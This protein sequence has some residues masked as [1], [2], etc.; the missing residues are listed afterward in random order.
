MR[1]A[2][3]ATTVL[4]LVMLALA[5]SGISSLAPRLQAATTPQLRPAPSEQ[6]NEELEYRFREVDA[7]LRH[8]RAHREWKRT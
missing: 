2:L 1:M 5:V 7:S 6:L 8:C 4:G 3:S